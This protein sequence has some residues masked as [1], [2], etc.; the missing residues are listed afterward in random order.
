MHIMLDNDVLDFF[1][2]RAARP[3][4]DPERVAAYSGGPGGATPALPDAS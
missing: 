4:A 3:G 1:K 2:A